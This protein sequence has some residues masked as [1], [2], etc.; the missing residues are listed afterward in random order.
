MGS[1]EQRIARQKVG[2]ADGPK[3]GIADGPVASAGPAAG[4]AGGKVDDG[5]VKNARECRDMG[6]MDVSMLCVAFG[7]AGDPVRLADPSSGE[8][9]IQ[10]QI[11][12][13][14]IVERKEF[15][16]AERSRFA[17]GLFHEFSLARGQRFAAKPIF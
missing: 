3:V 4:A 11:P 7:L 17:E 16:L 14:Q 6:Y 9:H 8:P 5:S 10:G 12:L 1:V 15:S 2:I 13:I